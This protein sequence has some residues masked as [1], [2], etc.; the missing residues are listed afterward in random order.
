MLSFKKIDFET[1]CN[2]RAMTEKLFKKPKNKN[3][4]YAEESKGYE[5]ED[6]ELDVEKIKIPNKFF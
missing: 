4:P 6:F 2:R 5:S 3:H 1:V